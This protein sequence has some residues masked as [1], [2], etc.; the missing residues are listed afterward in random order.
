MKDTQR[1]YEMTIRDSQFEAQIINFVSSDEDFDGW[2][3]RLYLLEKR[4][5]GIGIHNVNRLERGKDD[6]PII[7][8]TYHIEDRP[9]FRPIQYCAQLLL[10]WFVIVDTRY[11]VDNSCGYV[12]DILKRILEDRGDKQRIEIPMG[13]VI[14]YLGTMQ[15]LK[16]AHGSEILEVSRIINKLYRKAKHEFDYD[17]DE[18]THSQS[19]PLDLAS[20]LFTYEEAVAIYFGCRL[21]GM[22]LMEWMRNRD[23]E[24]RSLGELPEV[25]WEEFASITAQFS[26]NIRHWEPEL[27][28]KGKRYLDGL[29]RFS[30]K[31][32]GTGPAHERARRP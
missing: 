25:G 31:K 26:Y 10:T 3:R 4:I 9:I 27:V 15:Q 11:L 16:N 24:L 19:S 5:G 22:R 14:N 23:I 8:G 32:E 17:H 6:D 1:L 18:I 7:T 28:R 29:S 30:E 2:I 20:H 21:H 13:A 12:E